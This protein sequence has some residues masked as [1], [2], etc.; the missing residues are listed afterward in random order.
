MFLISPPWRTPA[1]WPSQQEMRWEGEIN[2]ST[3]R[4]YVLDNSYQSHVPTWPQSERDRGPR[5]TFAGPLS[6]VRYQRSSM[7]TIW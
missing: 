1:P 6:F 3:Q 7:F 4:V 2:A 5:R